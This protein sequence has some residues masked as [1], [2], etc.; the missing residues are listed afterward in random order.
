MNTWLFPVIFVKYLAPF[1]ADLLLIIILMKCLFFF[2]MLHV[3]RTCLYI[4]LY[5]DSYPWFKPKYSFISLHVYIPCQTVTGSIEFTVKFRLETHY[6]IFYGD[7][8]KQ[9][10][11]LFVIHII[12]S[13]SVFVCII[14]LCP[15]RKVK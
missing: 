3:S 14:W 13:N 8:K 6:Y 10:S 7:Q 15:G 2:Y 11:Y 9:D 5:T 4:V 12:L 1:C